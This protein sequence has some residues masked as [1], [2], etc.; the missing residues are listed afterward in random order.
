M[1]FGDLNMTTST[2]YTFDIEDVKTWAK[3]QLKFAQRDFSKQPNAARWNGALHA[4]FVYQ[5]ADF[6]SR[7]ACVDRKQ[8]IADLAGKPCGHWDDIISRATTSKSVRENLRDFA[9]A[10]I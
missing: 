1:T 7:S 4:M 9:V 3:T 10:S 6:A 2:A 8:L 5:Q